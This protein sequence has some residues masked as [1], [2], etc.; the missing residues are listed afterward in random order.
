MGNRSVGTQVKGI[1]LLLAAVLLGRGSYLRAQAVPAEAVKHTPGQAAARSY[2]AEELKG[3]ALFIENCAYC[4]L[5]RNENAK[6]PEPGKAVG[7]SLKA[8]FSGSKAMPE[9]VARG[10]IQKG[11]TKMPGFQYSFTAP[12]LDSLIAFLKTY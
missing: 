12:E 1:F 8:I 3:R 5:A 4:H 10:F 9:A 2:S 11:S 6:N 7:P